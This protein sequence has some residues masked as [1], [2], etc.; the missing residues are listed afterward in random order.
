MF[1]PEQ[2]RLFIEPSP[3]AS[4]IRCPAIFIQGLN[5]EVVPPEQTARIAAALYATGTDVAYLAFEGKNHGFRSA[6]TIRRT[7]EAEHELVR[8]LEPAREPS[9]FRSLSR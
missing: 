3:L 9:R 8:A 4:R 2:E 7:P 6:A 5:D 1:G